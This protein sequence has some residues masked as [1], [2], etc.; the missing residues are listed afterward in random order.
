MS[1]RD[2]MLA[3]LTVGPAYGFQLHGELRSRTAGRRSVN[4]GQIYGTLDRLM[5]QGAV[6]SAGATEDGLPLY[7]LTPSGRVQAREWLHATDSTPGEEWNDLVSRVLLACSLPDVDAFSIIARNRAAWEQAAIV[8][9]D[10]EAGA[11]SSAAERLAAHADTVLS[12]AALAW[13]GKV[14]EEL[15]RNG[16]E[17]FRREFSQDRPRRGRR[18]ANPP[19][20]VTSA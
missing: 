12:R 16:A 1:V 15:R 8:D 10:Q 11:D 17:A 6:E 2:G 5:R 7:R 9:E 3:I 19:A 14:E 20:Y 4:V 18:P 13:L